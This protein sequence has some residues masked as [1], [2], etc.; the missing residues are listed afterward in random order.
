MTCVKSP[1]IN[2]M[3]RYLHIMFLTDDIISCSRYFFKD[4]C[5]TSYKR[6]TKEG[7]YEGILFVYHKALVV[8]FFFSPIIFSFR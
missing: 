5:I 4:A 2:V 1:M 7:K 6:R 3:S 8:S